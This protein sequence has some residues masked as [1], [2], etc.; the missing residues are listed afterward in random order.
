MKQSCDRSAAGHCPQFEVGFAVR[1]LTPTS[2]S[3]VE[4]LQVWAPD[5]KAVGT[6][7]GSRV[8]D[9]SHVCPLQ[10]HQAQAV[11]PRPKLLALEVVGLECI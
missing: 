10:A 6:V 7:K 3:V 4:P 9:R 11:L 5:R 8:Q 2:G 1:P